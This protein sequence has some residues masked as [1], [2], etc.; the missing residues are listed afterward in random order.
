LETL[1]RVMGGQSTLAMLFKPGFQEEMSRSFGSLWPLVEAFRFQ[2]G[3]L[4]VV[5]AHPAFHWNLRLRKREIMEPLR[6]H[7]IRDIECR[8]RV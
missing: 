7:G 6:V 5:S 2:E 3:I 8:R 1:G 4:S